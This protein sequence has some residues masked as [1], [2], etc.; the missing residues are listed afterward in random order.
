MVRRTVSMGAGLGTGV[1]LGLLDAKYGK[2]SPTGTK[3]ARVPGTEIDADA[4]LAM[5]AGTLGVSGLAGDA[6]E[7]MVSVGVA[8]GA[9]A[10]RDWA[11]ET[12]LKK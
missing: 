1:L 11:Y 4:A 10:T 2:T 6:S 7:A 5:M 3:K 12:T 8:A 9:C